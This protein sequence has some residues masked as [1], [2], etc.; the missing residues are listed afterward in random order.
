MKRVFMVFV[1]LFCAVL[2]AAPKAKNAGG[3]IAVALDGEANSLIAIDDNSHRIIWQAARELQNYFR[4]LSGARIPIGNSVP[5]NAYCFILGT[6]DSQVVKPLLKGKAFALVKQIRDDGYAVIVRG[7]KVYI[8]GAVPRGVLNGVNRFIFNHTD[9]IW[10]RPHKELA[11][12]TFDPNLKLKVK[13]HLD[14]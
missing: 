12:F 5:S 13:D 14:L 2:T 6:P 11:N 4:Q 1:L 9:F 10:V 3:S 7:Q 8:I